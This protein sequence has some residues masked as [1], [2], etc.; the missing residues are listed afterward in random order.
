M[1]DMGEPVRIADLAGNLI[2]L[3]GY[4]PN[5]DIEIK[6]TGLGQGKKLFEEMLL[7][8]EGIQETENKLIYIGKPLMMDAEGFNRQLKELE[9]IANNNSGMDYYKVKEIASWLCDKS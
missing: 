1:L 7:F 3:S 4:K 9:V 5:E 2:S 6:F 8:E